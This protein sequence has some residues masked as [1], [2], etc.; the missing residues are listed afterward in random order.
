MNRVAVFV[1]AGYLFAQGS[2]LLTGQKRPRS[3]IEIDL[4]GVLSALEELACRLSGVQLLRIYWYDGTATGPSPQH[5]AVAYQPRVKLRLGFVNT[6][7][8]Q[9]GVDSLIVTDMITLARNGSMSDALL[10]SGDEDIRVGVQQAQ[11]FGVRV[12]LLGITP[13]RGSQSQFLLQES[14]TTHEWGL[15]DVSKFLSH[16][17]RVVFP[18]SQSSKKPQ[19]ES[20]GNQGLSVGASV[21]AVADAAAK[22]I[23]IE[24]AVVDSLIA[25]YDAN[26]QLPPVVDR[27]LLGL[28]KKQLGLL[29]PDQREKLRAAF[30]ATLRKN[31]PTKPAS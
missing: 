13:C 1:D 30:V 14:D 24:P 21:E 10:L 31:R 12:H 17:P 28:A 25:N 19:P 23:R 20:G 27:P 16:R 29:N 3:E 9:K 2:A 8:E 4:N 7:G 11:E 18:V 15:A 5:L 26:H 6:A 22:E